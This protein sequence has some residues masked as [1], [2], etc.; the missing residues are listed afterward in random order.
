MKPVDRK[1]TEKELALLRIEQR[2]HLEQTLGRTLPLSLAFCPDCHAAQLVTS[3]A[4]H[5]FTKLCTCCGAIFGSRITT[6]PLPALC[7][8][9]KGIKPTLRHQPCKDNHH[10]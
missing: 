5:E 4:K 7:L 9:D 3:E 10:D 2:Q 6:H 8:F 1:A